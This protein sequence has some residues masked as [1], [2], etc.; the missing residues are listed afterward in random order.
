VVQHL[1][2]PAR[3]DFGHPQAARKKAV[4]AVDEKRE[5]EQREHRREL[6]LD[7][8]EQRPERD[9]GARGGEDV[10]GEGDNLA[11]RHLTLTFLLA[12]FSALVRRRVLPSPRSGLGAMKS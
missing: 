6:A 2:R 3:Q 8:R 4:Y 7:R 12:L 9:G 5:A 10:D 11:G 1:A